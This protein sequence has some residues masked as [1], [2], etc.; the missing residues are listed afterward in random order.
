VVKD[1]D[2]LCIGTGFAPPSFPFFDKNSF[3]SHPAVAIVS[4]TTSRFLRMFD[5]D[6]SSSAAFIALGARPLVGSIP[7]RK[8][9]KQR[10]S[11]VF[12]DVSITQRSFRSSQ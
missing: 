9:F 3:S 11:D 7:T 10:S 12:A 5:P 8:S 4:A 1:V 2:A 6:L